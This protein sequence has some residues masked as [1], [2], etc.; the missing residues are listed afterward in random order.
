MDKETDEEMR[1]SDRLLEKVMRTF[2]REKKE[3]TKVGILYTSAIP[4]DFAYGQGII[5]DGQS[6]TKGFINHCTL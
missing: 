3:I 5:F 2:Q 4:W 1:S 6:W